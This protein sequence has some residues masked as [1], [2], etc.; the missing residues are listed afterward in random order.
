MIA[1]PLR[2]LVVDDTVTYRKIVTNV[3]AD[4]PGVEVVG[5]APNGKIALEKIEQLRPDLITLDIEMPTLDG[6]EVL[7]RLRD[8]NSEV[9]VIMLSGSTD[10]GAKATMKALRLGAFDF[11]LKPV[12]NDY[13]ANTKRYAAS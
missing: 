12:G 7:R 5:S 4:I 13:V 6:L 11:V 10:D 8:S 2:I 1:E 3:V 9:G